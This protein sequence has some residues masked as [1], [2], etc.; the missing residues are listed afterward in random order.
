MVSLQLG[1]DTVDG[2]LFNA[3]A[4]ILCCSLKFQKAV[5]LLRLFNT[6]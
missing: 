2:S 6:L 5:R 3:Y 1:W 4:D